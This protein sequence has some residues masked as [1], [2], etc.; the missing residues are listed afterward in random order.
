MTLA[1]TLPLSW[2]KLVVRTTG[3]SVRST[4]RRQQT[5]TL[6]WAELHQEDL[7]ANWE[8]VMGGEEPFKIQPLQ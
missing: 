3:K 8:L 2:N 6:A 5:L 1:V 7:R 4:P